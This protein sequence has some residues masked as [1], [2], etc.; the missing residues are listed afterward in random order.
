VQVP[1][2]GLSKTK[3]ALA[4][5]RDPLGFLLTNAKAHGP[6]VQLCPGTVMVTGRREAMSVLRA[7]GEDFFLDRDFLNRDLP[8]EQGS[9]QDRQWLSTRRAAV[10]EMTPERVRRH[11]EW[12]VPRA[13]ALAQ[14]WQKRGIVTE[15]RHDL[16]RLTADSIARFCLGAGAGD[17]VPSSAQELLDALFPLFASPYR[18]PRLIRRLQPREWRV[19]R[20][21]DDF[22]EAL[23]SELAASADGHGH[24]A[25]DSLAA[26][27]R[28][29]GV[30][31]DALADLMR[32]LILAAH[33]VPASALAWAVTELARSPRAQDD[34]AAAAASWDGTGRPPPQIAWF[35]DE[36][37]RLWPPTWGLSRNTGAEAPC[38][39]WKIPARSAVIVP[40]WVLHR[41]CPSYTGSDPERFDSRRWETIK[42]RP[43]EYLPFS[44][45]PRWC[46]GER[47]ARAEL[48]AMIAVLS[49]R[50]RLTLCGEVSPDIRRT[51]TPRGFQV[52]VSPR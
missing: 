50:T 10:A 24:A 35:V 42:P 45:G 8:A 22:Y 19:R 27:V 34:L 40:L 41:A 25:S 4:Y 28:A 5:D 3:V 33:D 29:S 48:A 49:R 2:T 15:L 26:A 47:L 30:E 32:S 31:G 11:M 37:L 9:E 44:G 14:Q 17:Q 6:V 38:G 46:P 16:E 20:A 7:T 12:F 21:L 52:E 43:G 13:E 1:D 23:R 18:M 39:D 36:T 51:L